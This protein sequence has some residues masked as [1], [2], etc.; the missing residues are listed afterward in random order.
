M[1]SQPAPN[2]GD[3][4]L[5]E[6]GLPRRAAGPLGGTKVFFSYPLLGESVFCIAQEV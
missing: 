5:A 6:D 4:K 1:E 3:S 2:G